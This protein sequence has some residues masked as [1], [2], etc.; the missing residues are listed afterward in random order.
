MLYRA[1]FYNLLFVLLVNHFVMCFVCV[2]TDLG[3]AERTSQQQWVGVAPHDTPA[4]EQLIRR[5]PEVIAVFCNNYRKCWGTECRSSVMNNR[6]KHWLERPD[7]RR[8]CHELS[9]D[10]KVSD[11]MRT[12]DC[13]STTKGVCL[14]VFA[15][16]VVWRDYNRCDVFLISLLYYYTVHFLNNLLFVQLVNHFVMCVVR[17]VTDLGRAERPSQQ[18]WVGVA[19]HDT[20]AFEQLIRRSPKWLQFFC[21]HYGKCWGTECRSHVINNRQKRSFERPEVL[22]CRHELST[23]HKGS[24]IRWTRVVCFI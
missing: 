7:V 5:S 14:C 24:N 10:H 8:C 13:W 11:I 21:N 15:N 16:P 18:Q 19:P 3:R 4:F 12:V 6:Q 17:V 22:H 20:P 23:D 1:F 2:V 9:T